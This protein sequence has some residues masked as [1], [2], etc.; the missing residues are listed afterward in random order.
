MNLGLL[1]ALPR[2]G[3]HHLRQRHLYK[4]DQ[5]R[6]ESELPPS[7]IAL[8]GGE[9]GTARF[10]AAG[11]HVIFSFRAGTQDLILKLA[12]EQLRGV[13]EINSEAEWVNYLASAGLPVCRPYLSVNSKY[14]EPIEVRGRGRFLAFVTQKSP[15]EPTQVNKLL[16][17]PA[18]IEQWGTL[19][20]RIHAASKH[21]RPGSDVHF[22]EMISPQTI[23]IAGDIVKRREPRVISRLSA[24]TESLLSLPR[25]RDWFGL[26][27]GDF[28]PS[29][30]FISDHYL[31]LL[32]FETSS[33][34]WFV[35]DLASPLYS[36]LLHRAVV[37]S[38]DNQEVHRFFRSFITGYTR[39]NVLPPELIT[40]LPQFV[41]FLGLLHVVL[42]YD[43]AAHR[44]DKFLLRAVKSAV[45]TMAKIEATEFARI[46]ADVLT[47]LSARKS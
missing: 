24:I 4:V 14:V 20:G 21:F 45:N 2:L 36:L 32:D 3:I 39:A 5:R 6:W 15:G 8:W 40:R 35:Y 17:S 27:H 22:R 33:Y 26:V 13:R 44:P 42:F 1:L 10:V 7:T 38:S 29:N 9:A 46:Y 28:T 16:S 47:N 25:D 12:R 43:A 37:P 19:A 31:T 18:L 23:K 11:K 34:C 41:M 30:L